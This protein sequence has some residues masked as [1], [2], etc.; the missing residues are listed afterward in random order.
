[1]QVKL[2]YLGPNDSAERGDESRLMEVT[3]IDD[4]REFPQADADFRFAAAV[5]SFGMQLRRS[6][7]AGDWTMRDVLEVAQDSTGK[8]LYELRA[9][10]LDLV[11]LAGNR[12]GEL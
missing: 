10:F 11:R 6:P 9:E 2:R 3:V 8:D 5:A 7:H 4:D 12:M 1:M